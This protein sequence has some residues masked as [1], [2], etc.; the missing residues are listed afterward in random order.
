MAERPCRIARAL[1]TSGASL[2]LGVLLSLVAALPLTGQSTGT[3]TGRVTDAT[4]GLGLQ[5]V[6]VFA[7]GTTA[8]ALTQRDGTYDSPSLRDAMRSAPGRWATGL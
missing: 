1:R 2:A 5:G 6:S 7:V 4:T 8:R 3:L